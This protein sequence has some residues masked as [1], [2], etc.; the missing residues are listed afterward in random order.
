MRRIGGIAAPP[1]ASVIPSP[2]P[3]GWRGK[4][5]FHLS[6]GSGKKSAIGLMAARSNRIVAVGRCLV[7]EESINFKYMKLIDSVKN[8]AFF[9]PHDR[10][11]VWA[12]EPNEP[13][14]DVFV[15]SGKS[16]D[17]Q[18][19]VMKKRMTVPGRGFFQANIFLVETLV[20]QVVAMAALT[21]KE[22]VID[23]YGSVGL[24]SLFLG[25]GAGSLFCIE[26]DEEAL[27][28]ARKN[29]D[30]EGIARAACYQG[31]AADVLRRI[32][33]E[34]KLKVDVV[35]LD[36]PRDGC[37]EGAIAALLALMPGR[38][39][40]VSCNPATQ[41]RDIKKFLESGYCLETVQPLDMFPQTPHVEA[42]ALLTRH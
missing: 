15:G 22:T 40:Y 11:V 21:G 31:D 7:V 3:F 28:C 10:Q 19:V 35:V 24:F 38:I 8:G 30:S 23:L 16:P 26:G 4:A 20:E 9:S 1:A 5:E 41:A 29:L 33:V 14:V 12:D 39:V 25:G 6:G 37:A 36:P 27:R 34:P 18:R 17:V 42:V 13:P 2:E 32:F